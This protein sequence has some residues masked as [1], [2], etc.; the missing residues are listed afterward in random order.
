[1]STLPNKQVKAGKVA[2]PFLFPVSFKVKAIILASV[3]FLFYAN[4]VLNK[5][6]F[7]DN[8][9]IL[10]NGYVQMGFS[11]IPKI[12]TNDS[13]A[14]YYNLMGASAANQLSGGRYRPLSEITFAIEQ[15]FFG[16]SDILPYIRHLVNV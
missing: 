8:G 12:L 3:C 14:S 15:Q 6:A 16:D 2:K 4:S 9:A 7:D 1:M 11:G 13:Y 5:Y 10:N